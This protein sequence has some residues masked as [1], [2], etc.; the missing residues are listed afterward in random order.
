[1]LD[2]NLESW[3]K[4]IATGELDIID[5]IGLDFGDF[6]GHRHVDLEDQT[7]KTTDVESTGDV[8]SD[9]QTTSQLNTTQEF[10]SM[11]EDEKKS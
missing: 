2:D 3:A 11:T 7:V 4:Q 6:M 10:S 1:M 8:V 5:A 9:S